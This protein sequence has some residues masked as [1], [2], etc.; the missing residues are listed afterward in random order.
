MLPYEP[1]YKI[2][3]PLLGAAVRQEAARAGTLLNLGLFADNAARTLEQIAAQ[4][5]VRVVAREQS[6][7]GPVARVELAAGA[8][9]TALAALPGVQIVEPFHRRVSANDLSRVTVGIAT[10]TTTPANYLNLQGLNV[11]VAMND[12]GVDATHPDF[13]TGGSAGSGAGGAPI[14]VIGDAVQSLV[15]TN[16]HGTSVAG[17]IAGNGA[18][19]YSTM[20][21]GAQM[22][23][24]SVSNADFRGKAPLAT[25]YS[26][27]GVDGGADTNVIS[28]RYFQEQAAQT[29]ALIDNNSWGYGGDNTYDLA[30]ASYDAATR[31]AL[32]EIMG[33]QPVLFV[34]AAGNDGYLGQNGANGDDNGGSTTA[35]TITSPGTAKDVITVGALEQLR[36]ITN[37]VTDVKSNLSPVWEPQTDTGYQVA[38]Y[39]ARGNV[40]IGIEGPTGRLKPDVAAPGT[41]VVST[42]SAQWATNAYYNPTNYTAQTYTSQ[43]VAAGAVQY[44]SLFVP[45]NAVSATVQVVA[46]HSSPNPF[47]GL[48]VYVSQ[49]NFPDPTDP[50]T[51]DFMQTNQVTIPPDG[52][53]NYLTTIQG[54]GF[55]FAVGNPYSQSVSYNVFTEVAS[56]NDLG[57]YYSVLE[58]MNDRLGGYYRYESGTSMAAADVSGTLALIQD[59]FTNQ[60]QLTPS[61]ALLK[62]MI[63][64]GARPTLPSYNYQASNPVNNEGW[65]LVNLPNTLP[66]N[67]PASYNGTVPSTVYLQDQ[68]PTN[69]LATGGSHSF[70]LTLTTNASNLPLRL[71][72]AW[73]D[74]PGDPVAAI[75]LVNNLQLVVTNLDD[76]TNPL[77]YYGNNIASSGYNPGQNPTN[78]VKLDT[79]NNVQN[80]VIPQPLGTN[81]AVAVLGREVNVNA[82]SAQTNTYAGNV[83]PTPAYAPDVVQD[84]ALVISA[85]D[86]F[87]VKDNGLLAN[88]AGDQNLTFV[89]ATNTPLFNQFVGANSPVLATN[90]VAFSANQAYGGNAQDTLGTTNQWHFYVVTNN[91]ADSSG[92]TSDVTN[93]AFIVFSPETLSLSRMSVFEGALTNAVQ[94]QANI[95]LFVTTDP[96]LTNLYPTVISNCIN[97]PQAGAT[98]GGVFNGAAL[99]RGGAKFVVDTNSTHGQVYYVG[100]KSEDQLAAEYTFLPAFTATPVSLM[101]NGNEILTGIPLPAAIPGG[102]PSVPGFVDVVAIALT[103]V[104]AAAVIVTNVIQQTSVGDLVS[105]L[106][107]NNLSVVLMNHNSPNTVGTFG[108]VYDDGGNVDPATRARRLYPGTLRRPGQPAGVPGPECFVG[109]VGVPRGQ[110][111]GTLHRERAGLEHPHPA[112]GVADHRHHQHAGGAEMGLLQRGRAAGGDQPDH[113]RHQPQ[114]HAQRAAP[115]AAGCLCQ[116][117]RAAHDQ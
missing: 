58:G 48:P 20:V 4:P 113:Q 96:N 115:A 62:A 70:A 72:L 102:N 8:D 40:G 7:F 68:S 57:N 108:F 77:V 64:N 15:D 83:T 41:F 65:G 105:S 106:T 10:N 30:A 12:S 88:P 59:F 43:S 18:K 66:T 2:Q 50:S 5:G 116:A 6:P 93:A 89:S 36:H 14:R 34:F 21:G 27:G 28:D 74:P 22:A 79:I 97:G 71:T 44:Y 37:V 9:W 61:P 98:A 111:R 49:Y 75:K 51:Y 103:P 42:R 33:S 39:S 104:T 94:P 90:A 112:A 67:T 95:D 1:Y 52:P 24:G 54:T 47:P 56:T 99:N 55:N 53:A 69:A 23:E 107:Y 60:L 29:N 87:A 73:T 82:V 26:I 101:Q 46:N 17:I 32:P 78:I 76:P 92:S 3:M 81:Y 31:D 38:S 63:I 35:G 86:A 110:Q 109:R 117:G 80:I 85:G 84:Y 11:L 100:V 25:L 114:R 16:G 91:A 45:A 19:S 13:T